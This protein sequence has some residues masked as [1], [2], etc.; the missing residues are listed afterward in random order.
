M[1]ETALLRQ[2]EIA[3]RQLGRVDSIEGLILA[4]FDDPPDEARTWADEHGIEVLVSPHVRPGVMY[5]VNPAALGDLVR[6]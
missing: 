3:R 1:N 2:L 5:L 6:H 4:S